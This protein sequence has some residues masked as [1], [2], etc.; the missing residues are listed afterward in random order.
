MLEK[1]LCCHSSEAIPPRGMLLNRAGLLDKHPAWRDRADR[2]KRERRLS[3]WHADRAV[4]I[5]C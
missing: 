4:D 1:C 3:Q 5:S 2:A